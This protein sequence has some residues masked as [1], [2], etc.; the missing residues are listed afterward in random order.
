MKTYASRLLAGLS[1]VLAGGADA[2][3]VDLGDSI[4]DPMPAGHAVEYG[5]SWM[6]RARVLGVIP[7]EDSSNWVGVPAGADLSIDNSIVPEL[8]FTYFFTPNLAVELIAGVTPHD[9]DGRGSLAGAQI[10]DA[11]LLPPTLLLQYHFDVEHG[12][13]PY[14]GAGVNYTLFFNEDHGPAFT[15]LELD[16]SWGLALQAGVDIPLRDNWYLNIDVKKIWIQTDATVSGG[17]VTAEVD[18]DPWIVGVGIGY[19][20]GGGWGPLK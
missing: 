1:L 4:K 19:R 9:I 12:I 16:S 2:R 7:A 15:G 3:A 6:I 17:A 5:R 20:F 8:D 13:K 18:I 14:V 11:W 10:G